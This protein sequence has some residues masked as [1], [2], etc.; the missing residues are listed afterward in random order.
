LVPCLNPPHRR[1]GLRSRGDSIFTG[2]SG[3]W[4][5]APYRRWS[6]SATTSTVAPSG[7]TDSR[8]L[9]G[10]PAFATE[11]VAHRPLVFSRFQRDRSCRL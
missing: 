11:P 7:W 1:F 10:W 5:R 3:S 2:S 6:P 4:P 8:S 9:W